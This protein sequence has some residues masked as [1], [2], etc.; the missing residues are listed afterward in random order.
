MT[1]K[2]PYTSLS[3][4]L[5][6]YFLC[7]LISALQISLLYFAQGGL[8]QL[9]QGGSCRRNPSQQHPTLLMELVG[10]CLRWNFARLAFHMRETTGYS[11]FQQERLRLEQSTLEHDGD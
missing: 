7:L 1:L 3:N 10:L 5:F 4:K 8:M 11:F 2:M 9:C 6:F